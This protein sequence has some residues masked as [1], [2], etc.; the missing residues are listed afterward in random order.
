LPALAPPTP[1]M[2]ADTF[3][4]LVVLETL[5]DAEI[6]HHLETRSGSMERFR[7]EL[8][9]RVSDLVDEIDSL[10]AVAAARTY[11]AIVDFLAELPEDAEDLVEVAIRFRRAVDRLVGRGLSRRDLNE[12]STWAIVL[13]Q[14]LTEL[15]DSYHRAVSEGGEIQPREYLHARLLLARAREAAD[16]MLWEAGDEAS[17]ALRSEMD[18]LT[19]AVRHQHLSPQAVDLLIGAPRRRASAYRPSKLTRIGAFVLG[20][21]LRRSPSRPAGEP[22][23][24]PSRGHASRAGDPHPTQS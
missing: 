9:A 21:V 17:E 16:R 8:V 10:D 5:I 23:R 3:A 24:S 13:D 7:E 12:P 14:L 18:R 22:A 15:A 4:R 6:G 2:K 20:Q 1:E 19:F 11:D